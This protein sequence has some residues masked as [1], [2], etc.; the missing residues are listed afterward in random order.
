MVNYPLQVDRPKTLLDWLGMKHKGIVTLVGAGG[1]TT[2]MYRLAQEI[3]DRGQRV[4]STTTTRIAWPEPSQSQVVLAAGSPR[5]LIGPL[6]KSLDKNSHV[7]IGRSS[8]ESGRKLEGFDPSQI[9]ELADILPAEWILVEGDGAARKPL[10]APADYEPVIP[11]RSCLVLGVIGLT[12]IGKEI[13]EENI[14]R[15][16]LFAELIGYPMGY[17][18]NVGC[19]ADLICHQQGLLKGLPP[20]TEAAV[21]L[22]QAETENRLESGKKVVRLLEGRCPQKLVTVAI[23]CARMKTPVV[24]A[25]YYTQQA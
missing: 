5:N 17:R 2:L 23:G 24:W 10:K 20:E 4:V 21:F 12:C 14:H 11:S 13:T 9:D 1:K 22:N 19:L 6:A 16:K 8:D 7:T 3:V 18:L 25:R 15:A